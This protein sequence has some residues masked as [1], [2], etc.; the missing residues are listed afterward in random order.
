MEVMASSSLTS[1]LPHAPPPS[2]CPATP[3]GGGSLWK[4]QI[5]VQVKPQSSSSLM[6][7]KFLI[8]RPLLRCPPARKFLPLCKILPGSKILGKSNCHLPAVSWG[9]AVWVKL[10]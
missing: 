9:G 5:Q 4:A 2:L 7:P 6:M 10:W 3:M 8:P 1:T